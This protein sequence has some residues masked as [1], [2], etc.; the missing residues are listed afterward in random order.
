MLVRPSQQRTEDP[1]RPVLRGYVFQC[2]VNSIVKVRRIT[3]GGQ[4][5]LPAGVRRRWNTSSVAVDDHGD[6]VVIRPLPEDPVR[7]A[8]GALKGKIDSELMRKRA[9]SDEAAAERRV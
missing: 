3:A 5:S 1:E 6:H 4:L 2:N 8:R 9:R 7:A